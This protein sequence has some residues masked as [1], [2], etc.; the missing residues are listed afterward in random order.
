MIWRTGSKIQAI[1][2]K[3]PSPINQKQVI[4]F[5]VL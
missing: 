2:I 5:A 3:Q 1:L 4:E